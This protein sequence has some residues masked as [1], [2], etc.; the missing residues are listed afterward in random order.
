MWGLIIGIGLLVTEEIINAFQDH[1]VIGPKAANEITL[2]TIADGAVYPLIWGRGRV[3]QSI[4]AW[5]DTPVRISRSTGAINFFDYY[6]SM[7]YVLGLGFLNGKQNI[8]NIWAGESE[9]VQVQPGGSVATNL[10]DLV[11]DGNFEDAAPS[12]REVMVKLD[13]DPGQP[14]SQLLVNGMVEFLNGNTEQLIVDDIGT[15]LTR[16]G[17]HQTVAQ[18]IGGDSTF[19]TIDPR[20]APS[21]RGLVSVFL[22]GPSAVGHW[23]TGTTGQAQAY[24]FEASSYPTDASYPSQGLYGNYSGNANPADVIFDCLTGWAKLGLSRDLID[25]P[26]FQAA[27]YTLWTEDHGYSRIIE[28][29]RGAADIIQEILVQIAGVLYED[30]LTSKLVLK[31]IRNDYNPPDLPVIDKTNASDITVTCGG[32]VNLPNKIRVVYTD[33]INEYN[34]GSVT[35]QNLANA[36]GQGLVREQVLEMRGITKSTT[37]Q[38]VAE[39]ELAAR[40]SPLMTI[41]VTV[42]RSFIRLRPGD[43]VRVNWSKPDVSGLI[44][45]VVSPDRGTL[46]DGR[47][48]LDLVQD[49]F[50]VWRNRPPVVTGFGGHT[51]DT[52]GLV[53]GG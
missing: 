49:P 47:V 42:D 31:L 21:Y 45:R 10:G 14:D 35:A 27:A 48:I 7:H 8:W 12:H 1:P 3:R 38:S 16:L 51:V 28:E 22:C 25:M 18:T 5:C 34:D 37:A 44:F 6:L 24:S 36:V 43:P 23:Y 17:Q 52:S 9:M 15:A 13:S 4:L 19:G 41:K 2:P 39:R 53:S 29:A 40:S 11:G 46:E 50:Y 33:P 26:S 20:Y 32:W 30:A